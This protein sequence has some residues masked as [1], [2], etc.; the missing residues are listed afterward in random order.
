MTQALP[1]PGKLTQTIHTKA[2]PNRDPIRLSSGGN[3]APDYRKAQ[4]MNQDQTL[5]LE[6]IA[7]WGAVID[8]MTAQYQAQKLANDP[9]KRKKKTLK[10]MI[11]TPRFCYPL[12]IGRTQTL[13]RLD[14][15]EMQEI[16]IYDEKC[17]THDYESACPCC[18]N[19][20]K[21]CQEPLEELNKCADCFAD[22]RDCVCEIEETN[23]IYPAVNVV[24]KEMEKNC[25]ACGLFYV[26]SHSCS[27]A[28]DELIEGI[29]NAIYKVFP[30]FDNNIKKETW[31]FM[32][33][34][35]EEIC[36]QLGKE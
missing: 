26:G 19:I 14:T 35:V 29:S 16:E 2:E 7:Q 12:S 36:S 13:P 33:L 5:A 9:K 28:F 21:N 3:T 15:K 22:Q 30:N 11:D 32:V 8:Q 23:A 1:I 6:E 17:C 4:E 34:S 18:L 10:P 31:D 25:G 27:V 24:S 20:C